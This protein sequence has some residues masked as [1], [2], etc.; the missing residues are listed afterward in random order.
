MLKIRSKL[1]FFLKDIKLDQNVVPFNL[2]FNADRPGTFTTLIEFLSLPDDV[3]VI[4]V[5]FRVTENAI[6]DS[7]IAYLKFSSCV[8]DPIIQKVPLVCI[9]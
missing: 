2:K 7:T 4:P 5:E 9:Y 3:R 1:K 8:F 6:S